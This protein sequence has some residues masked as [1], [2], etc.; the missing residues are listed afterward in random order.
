M[1]T[2]AASVSGLR[3]SRIPCQALTAK[4]DGRAY[5]PMQTDWQLNANL[6][7]GTQAE[8]IRSTQRVR[9]ASSPG[10][11]WRMTSVRITRQQWWAI[12][13]FKSQIVFRTECI[14]K[15][16]VKVIWQ[17]A[18]NG[19]PILRL[20]VTPGGRKLYHWIPGVCLFVLTWST[21]VTDGRTDRQTPHHGTDRAYA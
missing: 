8:F 6:P 21:N 12:S 16:E 19:G 10:T 17:K 4:L 14:V 11:V 20:G 9:G 15:Q 13:Q 5:I 1:Q 3:E 2:C 7:T 18:P